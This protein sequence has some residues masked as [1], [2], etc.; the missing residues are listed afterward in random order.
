MGDRRAALDRDRRLQGPRGAAYDRTA[1]DRR[2]AGTERR[3]R[4][5]LPVD[6]P[7]GGARTHLLALAEADTRAEPE[8]EADEGAAHASPYSFPDALELADPV[9]V[10]ELD[11]GGTGAREAAGL[12][13]REDPRAAAGSLVRPQGTWGFLG[14][15]SRRA[16]AVKGPWH[17]V[18]N[19]LWFRRDEE[20]GG[21]EV[22][23]NHQA[24]EAPLRGDYGMGPTEW[25]SVVAHVS[26]RGET[27][28]QYD[29]A[30]ILH[31]GLEREKQ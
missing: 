24:S 2:V 16:V 26:H 17:H 20:T 11:A 8:R 13:S 18:S 19:G 15:V 29:A 4:A 7:A 12:P 6:D 27:A 1:D 14:R 23:V 28:E 30:L 22:A 21:V 31:Q 3:L 5:A 25:A 9:T 10:T